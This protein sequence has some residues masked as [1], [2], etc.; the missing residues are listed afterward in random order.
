MA[1]ALEGDRIAN[2][3]GTF[4]P[5]SPANGDMYFNTS[6]D[7]LYVYG[8]QGWGS[9]PFAPLGTSGNP[10]T[11]ISALASL[12]SNTSGAYYFDV[13]GAKQLYGDFSQTHGKYMSVF[14]CENYAGSGCTNNVW[15]F[16]LAGQSTTSGLPYSPT[17]A[18]GTG[19]GS[20]QSSYQGNARYLGF[21][22][23]D[24]ATARSTLGTS[25]HYMTFH[26]SNGTKYNGIYRNNSAAEGHQ[27]SNDGTADAFYWFCNGGT[28]AN[29]GSYSNG[30]MAQG[31]TDSGSTVYMYS[32]GNIYCNCCEGVYWNTSGYTTG[33][34]PMAFGDGQQD[35]GNVPS[36]TMFYI[37][38]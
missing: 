19:G 16:A 6:D 36:W 4:N 32:H 8:S 28:V 20:G 5:S 23:G 27:N 30:W 21:S 1:S 38:V 14:R 13:G 17:A 31:N 10:A 9:Q 25:K 2:A 26:Q 29:A 3:T 15:D 34:Q 35:D 24:R 37:G 11:S 7:R 18:W 22:A 33:N 12:T